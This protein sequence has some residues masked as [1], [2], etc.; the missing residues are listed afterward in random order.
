MQAE[1]APR[2]NA[3]EGWTADIGISPPVMISLQH[4]QK[5]FL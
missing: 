1:S 2:S 5:G 4:K 3:D